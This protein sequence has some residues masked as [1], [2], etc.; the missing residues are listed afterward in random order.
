MDVGIL[1][2]LKYNGPHIY[3]EAFIGGSWSKT[4]YTEVLTILVQFVKKLYL[5][6]CTNSNSAYDKSVPEKNILKRKSFNLIVLS[7][8]FYLWNY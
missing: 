7:L 4:N 2:P 3:A 1:C 8:S 6:N 5:N